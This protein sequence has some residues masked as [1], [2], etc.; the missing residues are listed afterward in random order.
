MRVQWIKNLNL[1]NILYFIF[2]SLCFL[3]SYSPQK[4]LF[5]SNQNTYFLHGLASAKYGF[6][7]NDWLAKTLD[8]FPIFSLGVKYLYLFGGKLSFLI[9]YW[10]LLLI[11]FWSL[12]LIILFVFNINSFRAKFLTACIIIFL[13]SNFLYKTYFVTNLFHTNHLSTLFVD[14]LAGQYLIG[15]GLE[16]SIFGIL[17]L[18]SIY[19]FFKGRYNFSIL[20]LISS[21]YLHS[22]YLLV[23][24]LMLSGYI[25]YIW[26]YGNRKIIIKIVSFYILL[27]IPLV[28][29]YYPYFTDS[30]RVKNEA[31][32]ILYNNRIPH[33]A[34]IRYWFNNE[35]L[36]KIII[37]IIGLLSNSNKKIIYVFVMPVLVAFMLSVI[38]YFTGS[39]FLGL[40]FPWRLSVILMP[41]CSSFIFLSLIMRAEIFHDKFLSKYLILALIIITLVVVSSS[42]QENYFA[43]TKKEPGDLQKLFDQ[44]RLIR[45]GKDQYFVPTN[46]EDFRLET[47]VPIF[48]DLKSHPYKASE[49]IEWYNRI[50]IA[51]NIINKDSTVN[52]ALVDTLT[53]KYGVTAF[54]FE[55]DKIKMNDFNNGDIYENDKYIVINSSNKKLINI[56]RKK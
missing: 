37:I 7:K 52:F 29:F 36:L 46:L 38:Q 27:I 31:L 18:I 33:H 10:I 49:V 17:I 56:Y 1:K 40:L 35:S 6:L 53:K 19:L 22:S 30:L 3:I 5:Y 39:K 16:P 24:A 34:N 48:V 9:F 13:H 50:K 23:S 42:G 41:I 4:L 25:S 55:K 2:I 47:G 12:T 28:F 32:N 26:L 43:Y 14:G 21:A 15:P 44:I 11:Y 8:P 45:T 20:T 54:V 51:N